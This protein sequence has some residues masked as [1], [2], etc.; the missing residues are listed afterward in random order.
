MTAG[1]LPT[2]RE[3]VVRA[4]SGDSDAFSELV[5]R[6]EAKIYGLCIKMLG[7]AEDAEDCLQ[8][9]FIKAFKALPGFRQ[10]AQFST[11]LYRIAYNECLMRIRKRKLD[12]VPID[13]PIELG[14]GPVERELVDWTSDPR[15]DVMN[16]ELSNV[17]LLHVN[18]LD[19]DNRIV[20]LLRDVH[21]LS[22]NDTADAL[23]LTV[24]AVKSR[25]HRARLFLRE[26]LTDYFEHGTEGHGVELPTVTPQ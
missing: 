19:P 8:E 24:P 15:A 26:K 22:T 1:K 6:N 12:T 4:K 10:A 13:R 9:V 7:N 21:G 20:F 16:D 17:L 25:L 23:G 5:E 2:D 18:E 3:L 11:W 14:E